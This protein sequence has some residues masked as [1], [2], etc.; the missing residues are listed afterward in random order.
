M[1]PITNLSLRLTRLPLDLKLNS[2]QNAAKFKLTQGSLMPQQLTWFYW[3]LIVSLILHQARTMAG[4]VDDTHKAVKGM[5]SK[6]DLTYQEKSRQLQKFIKQGVDLNEN[7]DGQTFLAQMLY[8]NSIREVILLIQHG[9][10]VNKPFDRVINEKVTPILYAVSENKLELAAALITMN[11]DVKQTA[12]MLMTM[13][14]QYK[15]SEM[16]ALLMKACSLREQDKVVYKARYPKVYA[17][18]EALEEKEH[19]THSFLFSKP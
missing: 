17:E 15:N 2:V 6:Q 1:K 16:V 9:A 14:F 11:A 18:Y 8:Q 3:L 12:L 4:R 19:E 7:I 10:N 13:A 5:L